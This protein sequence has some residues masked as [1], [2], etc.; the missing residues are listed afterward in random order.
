MWLWISIIVIL[1]SIIL[2]FSWVI[3][4]L[5]EQNERYESDLEWFQEWYSKFII[6]LSESDSKMKEIDT[7]GSFSSDDEIGFAYKTIQECI[8][9]LT[10]M[11]AITYGGQTNSTEEIQGQEEEE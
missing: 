11:G 2:F 3:Y 8:N 6:L 5:V 9:N 4:R 10:E 7:R 1:V